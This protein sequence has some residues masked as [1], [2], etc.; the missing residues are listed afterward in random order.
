MDQ[1]SHRGVTVDLRKIAAA[2][3]R[4]LVFDKFFHMQPGE[5][6]E[7][8]HSHHST[9]LRYLLLAEAPRGFTWAYLEQGP[10]LWRIRI[11][12]EQEMTKSASGAD[13]AEVSALH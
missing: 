2:E 13:A 3:R 8:V 6:L 5:T 12:K 1:A 9:P 11:R 4:P 10:Q 7:L